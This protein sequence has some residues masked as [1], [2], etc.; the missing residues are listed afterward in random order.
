M[1]TQKTRPDRAK[2]VLDGVEESK[3]KDNTALVVDEFKYVQG[4]SST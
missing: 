4:R 1:E 3:G 2:G